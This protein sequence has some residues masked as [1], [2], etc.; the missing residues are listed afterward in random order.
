MGAVRGSRICRGCGA[1]IPQ[2]GIRQCACRSRPRLAARL[3]RLPDPARR[4]IYNP[5]QVGMH[6]DIAIQLLSN[7]LIV[8]P[9]VKRVCAYPTARTRTPGALVQCRKVPRRRGCACSNLHAAIRSGAAMVPQD[10]RV[11]RCA[12]PRGLS[13]R[14]STYYG[15][16]TAAHMNSVPRCSRS[17]RRT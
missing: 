1:R 5:V 2:L 3:H 12:I 15:K 8:V 6:W 4:V 9:S 11:N 17:D 14:A 10:G 13:A 7:P 16:E